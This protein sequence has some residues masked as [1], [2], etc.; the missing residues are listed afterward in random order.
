M[1]KINKIGFQYLPAKLPVS[2][3]AVT[4]L[5]LDRFQAPQWAWGAAGVWFLLVWIICLVA[6]WNQNLVHPKNIE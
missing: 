1:K 2:S 4:W 3:T 5:L 6:V